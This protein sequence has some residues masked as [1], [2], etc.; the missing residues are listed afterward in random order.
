MVAATDR[1]WYDFDILTAGSLA[2]RQGC[3]RPSSRPI[4]RVLVPNDRAFQALVAD[5]VGPKYWFANERN[6]PR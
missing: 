1:N 4:C 5:L 3:A 6:E 2:A